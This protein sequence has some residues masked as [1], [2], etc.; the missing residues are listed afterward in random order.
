M[1]R[2]LLILGFAT[3]R[4]DFRARL[5]ASTGGVR[6]QFGIGGTK[7]SCAILRDGPLVFRFQ[8][9]IIFILQYIEIEHLISLRKAVT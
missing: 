6:S 7:N 4:S 1:E 2:Y 5:T 8:G 9:N 3:A